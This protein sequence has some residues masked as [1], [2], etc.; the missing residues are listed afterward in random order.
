[1][2]KSRV[3]TPDTASF[4]P[5]DHG[6]EHLFR[7][8]K[9]VVKINGFSLA[10]LDPSRP[11]EDGFLAGAGISKDEVDRWCGSGYANDPLYQEA[12]RKGIAS[13][14]GLKTKPSPPAPGK[15]IVIA[16]EPVGPE[17]K[18][19]WVLIGGRD[20]ALSEDELAAWPLLLKSIRTS[21]DYMPEPGMSR[22]VLGSDDRVIHADPVLRSRAISQPEVLSD[23]SANLRPIIEQRWPETEYFERHDLSIEVNGEP[24]WVRFHFGHA[25]GESEG[26]HLYVELRPLSEDD[27][28]PSGLVPD[29]RIAQAAG[30]ISDNFASSPNLTEISA[31]VETSPFHFHRLFSKQ[32][33]ISPKHYL[34]RLQMQI[35]KWMLRASRKPIGTIA[36]DTGFSSHGHFTA[37]FHRIVGMSPTQYRESN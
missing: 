19:V 1:M 36:M 33:N 23:L 17:S 34:L 3:M 24:T 8:L 35:A 20:S 6:S 5:W 22:V 16:T 27:V 12:L 2:S 32:M 21:F 31:S 18:A 13:G 29:D 14:R 10:I 9:G 28:P 25:P 26:E 37:T 11:R 15:Q 4:A 30:Y 7:L